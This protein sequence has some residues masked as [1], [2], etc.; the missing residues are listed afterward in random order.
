MYL[1]RASWHS[2]A[3][4]TEVSPCFFLSCKANARVNAHKM[5]DTSCTLREDFVLLYRHADKSLARPTSRCCRTDSI[6]SLEANLLLRSNN[7]QYVAA[8]CQ[9]PIEG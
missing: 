7:I 9:E 1:H 4:L 2:S 3:T 8:D 6:V 5:W